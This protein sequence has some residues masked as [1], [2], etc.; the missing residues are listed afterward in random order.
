MS[1]ELIGWIAI[2]V[3]FVLLALGV[4]VA[5]VMAVTGL[6]GYYLISGWD[7]AF[8]I[9]GST[10]FGKL[11]DYGFIAIP[12]F[13]L[14]GNFAFA[15][16]F[17]GDIFFTLR[18]WLGTIPG[19]LAQ[20]TVAA[21][22]VFGAACGS[23]LATCAMMTRIAVPEMEKYGYQRALALGSVAAGGPLASMIP[24]SIMMI[25]YGILTNQSI[26]KLLIAGILPGIVAALCM[27][28]MIY[29][30]VRLNPSLA[31]PIKR[32]AFRDRVIALKGTWS[33]LTLAILVMGGIY[34][35][36]FTS[37]EAGAVGAFGAL[38]LGLVSRRMTRRGLFE[39]TL[40]AVKTTSM[41]YLIVG[42]SFIFAF[43]LSVTGIPSILSKLLATLPVHRMVILILVMVFYLVLGCFM[44]ILSAIIITMPIIFPAIVKLGFDPIWFGVLI[45]HLQEV[46]LITPPFG[47]NLFIM[48]GIMPEV[49]WSELISGVFPFILTE[50]VILAIYI[51]FPQISLFLPSLMGP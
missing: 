40:D 16:R 36:V 51:I 27:M 32:I 14:M 1:P 42:M 44:D 39:S 6:A 34:S 30:R 10:L 24:P 47:L 15:A 20:S 4:P 18:Q 46:A 29:V 2:S 23:G 3:L 49:G 43:L 31:P 26:G 11:A 50:L 45:V 37:S 8:A 21:C 19:G 5:Y 35:G 28:L 38:I 17:G 7:P 25:I 41:I 22:A 12:L 48:K 13:I 9:A 33:I